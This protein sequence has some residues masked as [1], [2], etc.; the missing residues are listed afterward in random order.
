MKK[1]ILNIGI[2]LTKKEQ[3]EVSGGDMGLVDDCSRPSNNSCDPFAGQFFGNPAC[4][5]GE[6]CVLYNNLSGNIYGQCECP[7]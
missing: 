2:A 7:D 1:S 3:K 6:V 5:L 4:N